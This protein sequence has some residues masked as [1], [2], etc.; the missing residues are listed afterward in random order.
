M[1][2]ESGGLRG[3][4]RKAASLVVEMSPDE[5]DADTTVADLRPEIPRPVTVPAKSVEQIARELPGPNLEDISVHP[6]TAQAVPPAADGTVDFQAV[7]TAA[8]VVAAGFGAEQVLELIRQLPAELPLEAKR[9]TVKVSVGAMGRALGVTPET[10]VADASRKLAAIAAYAEQHQTL[11]LELVTKSQAA[12]AELEA[13]IA[14]RKRS[15]ALA[16]QRAEQI[17][18]QCKTEADRLD[19]VLEFF[20]QD[21]SPSRNAPPS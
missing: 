19:D 5:S 17:A 18:T 14:E 3:M 7:Y 16:Q 2:G 9:Q 11:T 20:T 8:N 6:G 15:I 21:V 4:L 10:V 1:N 13:Q 12:I